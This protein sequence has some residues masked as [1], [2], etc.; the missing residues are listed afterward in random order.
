MTSTLGQVI[1]GLGNVNFAK[2]SLEWRQYFNLQTP[3]KRLDEEKSTVALRFMLGSAVGTLPFFEQ[4]F[5][6][7]AETL[8]GY[9]EDRFWGK[10][11]FLGSVELRQPLARRLKG[12]LFLDLDEFKKIN[13][14]R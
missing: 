3:R 12:V 1:K 10:Y 5:V 13:D 7:G 11:M 9:R 8:R 6:G 2:F 14:L 4:S